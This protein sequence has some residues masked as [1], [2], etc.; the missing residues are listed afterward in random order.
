MAGAQGDSMGIAPETEG[1][2]GC[3]EKIRALGECA[4]STEVYHHEPHGAGH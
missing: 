1:Y 3:T 2:V 4:C